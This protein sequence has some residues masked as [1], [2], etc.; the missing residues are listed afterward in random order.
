MVM[1]IPNTPK[2]GKR[3]CLGDAIHFSSG[4]LQEILHSHEDPLVIEVDIEADTT[5][6]SLFLVD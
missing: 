6:R 2:A 4:D 1:S 3:P 5:K